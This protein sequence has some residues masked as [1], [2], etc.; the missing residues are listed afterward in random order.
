M[1]L[2]SPI[3]TLNYEINSFDISALGGP[4]ALA[5]R[6]PFSHFRVFAQPPLPMKLA[7]HESPSLY[8]PADIFS[9]AQFAQPA[10]Q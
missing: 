7:S 6:V 9:I 4:P 10:Q 5:K 1:D 2:G 3:C 8:L